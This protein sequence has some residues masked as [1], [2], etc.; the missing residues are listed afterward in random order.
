MQRMVNR[1]RIPLYY[2][3]TEH[4]ESSNQSF[5]CGSRDEII[6][7]ASLSIP[8]NHQAT[9]GL[10]IG[11]IDTEFCPLGLRKVICRH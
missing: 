5:F 10:S 1:E 11:G 6:L 7:P 3:D 2:A 9:K 4:S 8:I